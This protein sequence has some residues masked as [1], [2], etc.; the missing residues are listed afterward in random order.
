MA[1]MMTFA[2]A[3]AFTPNTTVNTSSGAVRGYISDGVFTFRSIQYAQAPVGDLRWRPPQAVAPWSGVRDATKDGPGCPQKC[4]LPKGTCPPTIDEACLTL[5]VFTAGLGG[6]PRSVLFFI[7]G[8][9]FYQGYAGGELYDGSHFARDHNVVVVCIQYRLGAL[10]FLYSG[11]DSAKQFTGNFGL[12]D[13]RLALRWTHANIG[14]FGGDPSQIT[15]FGQSAGAMSVACHM[16]M[17]E[18]A[19]LFARAILQSEAFALPFRRT[20]DY[21]TFT[22]DVAIK[23]GCSHPTSSTPYEACMRQLSWPH[24]IDAQVPTQEAKAQLQPYLPKLNPASSLSLSRTVTLIQVAAQKDLLVELGHLM[25]VFVPFSPV[26]GTA[27]LPEQPLE[28]LAGGR[29]HD[30]PLVMGTVRQEGV[31]FLYE[32]F[33]RRE[34]ALEEAALLSAT[35][36]VRAAAAIHHQYPPTEHETR[37]GDY[38][39]HSAVIT[40]DGLFH[41]AVRH[42]ALLLATSKQRASDVFVYHFD[43][44]FSFG[45]AAWTPKFTECIDAVCHSEELPYV[46]HTDV[47]AMLNV[48]FTPKEEVL[49]DA[50]Q[51]HWASFALRGKPLATWP[52]FGNATEIAMRFT[53]DESAAMGPEGRGVGS[54][55]EEAAYRPKCRFWDRLGYN[56]PA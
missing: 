38:H 33:P 18:S 22:K 44:K 34:S 24:V 51:A 31:L 4:G 48:S 29:W 28:A 36:G 25:T 2:A 54:H 43:H 45:K 19:A 35:F 12:L 16:V 5:N 40:T 7:H 9:D 17:E 30:K 23:G 39:N 8:G 21:P 56:W 11:P 20:K 1:L 41:C 52:R 3:A 46:F 6:A 42:A 27:E 10:G 49:S 50:M 32:A 53:T 37:S 14:R 26:I 15:L 13:Q 47:H 55:V